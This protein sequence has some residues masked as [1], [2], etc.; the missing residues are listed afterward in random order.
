MQTTIFT[1]SILNSPSNTYLISIGEDRVLKGEVAKLILE[2]FGQKIQ[3][4]LLT[5][6]FFEKGEA[7]LLQIGGKNLIFARPFD[8][9][10]KLLTILGIESCIKNAFKICEQNGF[11]SIS[12]TALSG[13]YLPDSENQIN[14]ISKLAIND[15]SSR[16]PNFCIKE[17]FLV[18]NNRKIFKV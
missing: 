9:D 12:I 17:I 4:E 11:E 16:S 3:E 10:F 8:Y 13:N 6:K 2:T 15:Y 14:E 1:G 18:N 5:Q 7:R